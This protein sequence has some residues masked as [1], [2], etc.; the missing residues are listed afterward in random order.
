MGLIL[1]GGKCLLNCTPAPAVPPAGHLAL[2]VCAA[3][4]VL[5]PLVVDVA[6][7]GH[8]GTDVGDEAA[9]AAVVDLCH[10]KIVYLDL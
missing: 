2:P 9:D 4:Q 5:E 1:G 7:V 3:E 10:F 8:H 6:H